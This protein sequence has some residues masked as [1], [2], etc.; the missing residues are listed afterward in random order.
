MDFQD[1]DENPDRVERGVL[2]RG[3]E[4]P[5]G[6]T[7]R[8][9]IGESYFFMFLSWLMTLCLSKLYFTTVGTQF[10]SYE[11]ILNSNC[12]N[13]MASICPRGNIACAGINFSRNDGDADH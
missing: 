7:D 4:D 6:R 2:R 5:S 8:F 3:E 11:V 13:M 9:G 1:R 10:S 12:E